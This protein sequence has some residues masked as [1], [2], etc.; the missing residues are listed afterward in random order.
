M[1][2]QSDCPEDNGIGSAEQ[3]GAFWVPAEALSN[4]DAE[5][6]DQLHLVAQIVSQNCEEGTTRVRLADASEVDIA[7]GIEARLLAVSASTTIDPS[8][9]HARAVGIVES[10]YAQLGYGEIVADDELEAYVHGD[11]G[12]LGLHAGGGGIHAIYDPTDTDSGRNSI[13]WPLNT[14]DSSI[15]ADLVAELRVAAQHRRLWYVARRAIDACL[16][17]DPARLSALSDDAI[18]AALVSAVTGS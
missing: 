18:V 9:L 6:G 11:V 7:G 1:H 4:P 12:Y 17:I 8:A 15:V 3:V 10:V 13:D 14:E 2:H 16:E 5:A